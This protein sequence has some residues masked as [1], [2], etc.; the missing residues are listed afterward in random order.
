MTVGVKMKSVRKEGILS[1]ERIVRNSFEEC[2]QE[3][4]SWRGYFK[5]LNEFVLITNLGELTVEKPVWVITFTGVYFL[6]EKNVDFFRYVNAFSAHT[7]YCAERKV[8]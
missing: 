7:N 3:W 2:P 4:S 8:K 5:I 6:L 1:D